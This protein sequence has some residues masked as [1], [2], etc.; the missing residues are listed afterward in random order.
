MGALA[1]RTAGRHPRL[2]LTDS[3]RRLVFVP[4]WAAAAM[5]LIDLPDARLV[6]T[7]GYAPILLVGAPFGSTHVSYW[8]AFTWSVVNQGHQPVDPG[9]MPSAAAALPHLPP[10]QT[11]A[12]RP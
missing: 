1:L 12:S 6:I 4:G 5:L 8:D 10:H 3:T 9:A 2:H 7:T 11:V